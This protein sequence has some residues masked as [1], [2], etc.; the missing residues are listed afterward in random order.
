MS[1]AGV[2][3]AQLSPGVTGQV[4]TDAKVGCVTRAIRRR[5]VESSDGQEPTR[6]ASKHMIFVLFLYRAYTS[7]K[8]RITWLQGTMLGRIRYIDITD[9]C[10]IPCIRLGKGVVV[11]TM[12]SKKFACGCERSRHDVVAG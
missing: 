12:Q 7:G 11:V 6:H 4:V 8:E 5:G 9:C 1:A 2:T 10:D 3:K